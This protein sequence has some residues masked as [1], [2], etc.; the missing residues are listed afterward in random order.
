M[1]TLNDR[2]LDRLTLRH[3]WR[4]T[5]AFKRDFYLALFIQ[6]STICFSTVLPFIVGKALSELVHPG[7]HLSGYVIAFS[8]V[9]AFT[10]LTNY[11]GFNAFFRLQPKVM[12]RLFNE[13]YA[14]LTRRG[15]SFHNNQVSGKLVTDALDYPTSYIQLSN[16]VMIDIIPFAVAIVSGLT[17]IFINSWM[18]GIVMLLM[19]LVAI[20][21]GITLRRRMA[22]F[23][24][25]R[26]EAR[27][28]MIS[29]YADSIVNIQTIKTF[30]REQDELE[31]HKALARKLQARQSHD[32]HLVAK[33]G[34]FRIF[35]LLAF[36]TIFI[37]LTI[38]LVDRDPSLLATGIFAFSY[39]ITLSNRLFAVGSMVRGFEES[40]LQAEPI[41]RAL[42][43]DHEVKD[44][45]DASKLA[46]AAGAV[47]FSDVEFHYADSSA[48]NVVFERLNLDIRPGEKVGLVGPS[49]GGKSTIT[50]LLLRFEDIQRGTIEIDGQDIAQVTQQS[51]RDAIAYVPQESLLFHRTIK[52]NIG[53]GRPDASDADIIRAAKDAVAH[54]FIMGLPD[55]YET[56]V[57]ERGIKLSGGQRQRIAIAR[58][59]LKD[60]PII[61]LDE[62]TSALDSES[63]VAIQNAL[64][65][66][67]EGRTAIVIAHRLSTIQRMDRIV[68]L[69]KGDISEQGSHK[70]LLKSEGLYA[71]LW[72]HQSG[73]FMK[74]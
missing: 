50:K 49:G 68:V 23:R 59:I 17:V 25:K 14:M 62:A 40:L 70:D 1:V 15:M 6:L 60:A 33:D 28:A 55:G 31:R 20:G 43:E 71:R 27:Q 52:E 58:A 7:H 45:P 61:V 4:T 24:L 34:S 54:E 53:Y 72:A 65:R 46:V 35:Y 21:T 36:E 2:S 5:Y 51:L 42:N 32:W 74:D 16:T 18:I 26:I 64:W 19:T 44:A 13:C 73:G 56:I 10:V 66:L 8:G 11:I 39:T 12:G 38:W 29:H 47:R 37:L 41:S 48:E 57:G 3:F 30:A 9:A 22:P 63:E 67:M 69:D